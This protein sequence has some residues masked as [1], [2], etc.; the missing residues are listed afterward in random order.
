M[1]TVYQSSLFVN[2]ND[3]DGS[4]IVEISYDLESDQHYLVRYIKS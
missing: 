4:K 1:L 2:F 3:I